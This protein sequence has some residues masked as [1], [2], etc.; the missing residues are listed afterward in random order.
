MYSNYTYR[1]ENNKREAGIETSVTL[2]TN[3]LVTYIFSKKIK[4][5]CAPIDTGILSII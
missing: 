2:H 1:T 4:R 5:Q 3:C